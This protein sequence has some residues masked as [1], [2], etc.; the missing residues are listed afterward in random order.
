[1]SDEKWN[2]KINPKAIL[3]VF[4]SFLGLIFSRKSRFLKYVFAIVTMILLCAIALFTGFHPLLYPI[5]VIVLNIL[6]C[7]IIKVP[8]GWII[9]S[10]IGIFGIAFIWMIRFF[11]LKGKAKKEV[12]TRDENGLVQSQLV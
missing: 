10:S 9:G 3:L 2:F 4:L 6:V 8:K 5:I 11:S 1:M 7:L 12:I